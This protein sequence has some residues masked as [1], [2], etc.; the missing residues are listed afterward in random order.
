MQKASVAIVAALQSDDPWYS[1]TSVVKA[2]ARMLSSYGHK[3]SLFVLEDYD[4]CN[5]AGIPV[6]RVIPS[7]KLTDYRSIDFVSEEHVDVSN[8]AASELS[9]WLRGF[10]FVFTHDLVFT[11][12]NLPYALAIR[13]VSDF[14]RDL[15]WLHWIHSYPGGHKDWWDLNHYAGDHKIVFPTKSGIPTIAT[16]FR[17]QEDHIISIP[18]IKDIRN[19]LKFNK[20]TNEIIELFPAILQADI[21][22]CYPSATDR[23]DSK[24]IKDLISV[25]SMLKKSGKTVCLIIPNQYSNRRDSKLVDPI[26]YYEKVARR[27]GL[28]P[29]E[30]AIF[31]SEI[32]NGKYAEGLPHKVVSDL[33]ACSN[34]FV[35]PSRSESFGFVLT[36][37]VL[38]GSCIPVLNPS[39]PA[40]LEVVCNHGIKFDFG[41]GRDMVVSDKTTAERYDRLI[42]DIICEFEGNKSIQARTYVRQHYNRDVIYEKYYKNILTPY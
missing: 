18:H 38:N 19:E 3:V 16:S 15:R 10:D 13:S 31:T 6:R 23:F 28:R 24:G 33:M 12:W 26:R 32:L 20:A 5:M 37:A 7:T 27:C 22:Q 35:F 2:Q 25:F 1:L 29:Y 40:Q 17:T 36:E 21:V 39:A 11:G 42:A 30:D 34:L 9:S 4:G 41:D 8:R 14:C